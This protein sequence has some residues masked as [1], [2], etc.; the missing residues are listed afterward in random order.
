MQIRSWMELDGC[1][2]GGGEIVQTRDD[3]D[4]RYFSFGFADSG[5]ETDWLRVFV[6]YA[7]VDVD[8]ESLSISRGC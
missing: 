3:S 7:D 1:L 8:D 4:S 5:M 6:G 2:N